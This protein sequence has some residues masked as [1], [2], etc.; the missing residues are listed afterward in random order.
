MNLSLLRF[1]FSL[2]FFN[3][4]VKY[5]YLRVAS[6]NDIIGVVL[7]TTGEFSVLKKDSDYPKKSTLENVDKSYF[8]LS[9]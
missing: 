6:L 5:T 8:D 9:K 3:S 7:E 1:F 2:F 4:S